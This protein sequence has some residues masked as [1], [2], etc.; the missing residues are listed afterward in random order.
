M[1][2]LEDVLSIQTV[3]HNQRNMVAFILKTCHQN[4]LQY[5]ITDGNIYITKGDINTTEYYPCIVAHMDTVHQFESNLTVVKINN[6][7]MAINQDTMKQVGIGGDDKVGVFIA[8]HLLLTQEKIKVV[9][10][11]DEEIGCEGSYKADVSFFHDCGYVLQFD[12][13]GNKDFITNAAGVELASK[14]F[15][16]KIPLETYKYNEASG[17]MTDV[18]A[19]KELSINISMANISCGYYNPHTM[20]EYVNILDVTKALQ[21]AMAIIQ[22]LGYV[23]YPH[24][25]EEFPKYNYRHYS[26]TSF[27]INEKEAKKKMLEL[28][29]NNS[30]MNDDEFIEELLD[31]AEV[32]SCSEFLEEY[33]PEYYDY[34]DNMYKFN[35]FEF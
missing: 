1:L 11:R 16:S 9:F 6:K 35:S 34:N 15:I 8:L 33:Y 29:P 19:L 21:F 7:L 20:W 27:F 30:S 31:E 24:E 22:D 13:M 28:F 2:I 3:T 14:E 5:T 10:F 18:M 12:R 4:N 26:K 23:Q 32:S 17:R 25:H